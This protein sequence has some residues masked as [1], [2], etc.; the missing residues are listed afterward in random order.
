[1][2]QKTQ[3]KSVIFG[4][5]GLTLTPEERSFFKK[6]KPLGLI[7]FDRNVQNPEQLRALIEDFR[8]VVGRSDAPVLV[9]QEGGRVTRLW[10]PYWRGLG[11]N[12]TYGDWYEESHQKAIDGVEKHAQILAEDLLSVGINVD[13]WPCLDVAQADTHEI[14]AKR[15]FSDKPDVV[16]VLADVGIKTALKNGLM[17]IIKHIPGYGRTK[18]DPHLGLP[19][20]NTDLD[21]LN[22][23]DFA[24]FKDINAPVWGMTAHVIYEALDKKKP[25]TLSPCVLNFIRK[26]IGFNGFLIC[27]DISMG[28]LKQFGSLN[29][30]A[31]DMIQAG[32]DCVLHCNS[33][34]EE[35]RQIAE[36]VPYLSEISLNRLIIAESLKNG[37]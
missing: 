30:L 35:M 19:V 23:T 24:P 37:N 20:V 13:C 27:D 21:T 18:V 16:S 34:M 9:D 7:I 29:Q 3:I 11:W 10:P 32:C 26:E 6:E 5:Q 25:A 2:K 33:N 8:K 4:C 31:S 1:M 15:C 22:K 12:R 28:A 14:M 36:V 17:P